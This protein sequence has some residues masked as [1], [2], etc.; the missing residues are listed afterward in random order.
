MQGFGI[1][2]ITSTNWAF[3]FGCS[4][5]S[6]QYMAVSNNPKRR[7]KGMADLINLHKL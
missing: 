5:I 1:D 2:I 6:N 7:L 4:K 3:S